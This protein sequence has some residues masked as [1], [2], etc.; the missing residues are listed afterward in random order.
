MPKKKLNYK[1]RLRLNKS[2]K[3]RPVEQTDIV[4]R[5]E[6]LRRLD[7]SAVRFMFYQRHNLLPFKKSTTS[8]L[9]TR[10]LYSVRAVKSRLQEIDKL[11]AKGYTIK[12]IVAKLT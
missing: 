5:G 3:P 4:R 8:E 2:Y 9:D 7:L 11:Q 10:H 1:V 6:L 12:E